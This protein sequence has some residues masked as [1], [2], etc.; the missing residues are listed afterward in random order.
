MRNRIRIALTLSLATV[1]L[2]AYVQFRFDLSVQAQS[3]SHIAPAADAEGPQKLGF[4]R[5]RL[6]VKYRASAATAT[7]QIVAALG[8][9]EMRRLTGTGVLVIKLPDDT[10]EEAFASHLRLQPNV[11]FAEPDYL[12]YP[13][14]AMTPDDPLYSSQWHLPVIACPEAWAMAGAND[15]IVLALCDTGVDATHPDLASKLVPGWNVVDNNSDTSPISP[16]GTWTAGTAAAV[17]NNAIGVAS[18]AFN[19]QIMPIRVSSRS[20]G[21][22]TISDLSE[23]VVW[24]ADHGARVASVSYLGGASGI[25]AEAGLYLQ[26]KG[27]VLV[28]ASGN[29]GTYLSVP[30]SPSMIV[31]GATLPTDEVAAFS[32]TGAYVDLAAPGLSILTTSPNGT[33]QEVSGTSFSAP[34]VAGTAALML[35]HNPN[36]TPAQ[37][38]TILKVSADDLE[39]E[40]WDPGSGWGRMNAGRAI[41]LVHGMINGAADTTSPALGFLQPQIGG[42]LNGLIGISGGELVEVNALDDGAVAQVS[43]MSDGL[44]VGADSEEPYRF[45]LNTSSF[46]AGSQ[47]TLA[48]VATDSA[49][50][51]KTVSTMVTATAGFDAT[52]PTAGFLHPLA[53]G[54]S[55]TVEAS[56]ATAVEVVAQDNTAVTSVSLI[57]DGVHLGT[58]TTA[59]YRFVWNTCSFVAGSQ[60]TLIATA[61]DQ[62]NNWST[63]EVTVT[64]TASSDTAAPVVSFQQPQ[65]DGQVGASPSEPITVNASDNIG[66][67]SVSLYADGNLV[68][69]SVM[70][71]YAFTWNTT[72]LAIG[73]RHTLAAVAVDQA[74]NSSTASITVT[75][76]V[77]DTISPQI[78]FRSPTQGERVN[79]EVRVN[80]SAIDNVA[81]R[82]VDLYADNRL[83]E[84]W[85]RAPYTMKWKTRNLAR[86]A[87]TLRGQAIDAAG[88]RAS[89]F[90]TVYVR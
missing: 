90:V 67:A 20:D 89:A 70:A 61:A 28:M 54:G 65:A 74:D 72:A 27:G 51:S 47:H 84:S 11:E 80:I 33:Y 52:P 49:G 71:P 55:A 83:V 6:L 79:N 48:A 45:V 69:T 59:P 77:R 57:A 62:A 21:A 85:S 15:D 66:V 10:D 14:Q 58:I 87:H 32:T 22:A 50:N 42:P 63:I 31:V 40:G 1:V 29:T 13:V 17:S 24:A 81:V 3:A 43:L 8:V 38:D 73:S 30:D 88:N 2:P 23:G 7:S 9:T 56:N 86:G 35:S 82:R 34:L 25:M 44:V 64:V 37:I 16:H 26:S 75:V 41:D 19:C 60:H 76:V 18:P 78:S 4:V 36:L 12:L 46:V 53:S 68:G 39:P 5:G